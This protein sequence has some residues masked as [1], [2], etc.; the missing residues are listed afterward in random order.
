[1]TVRDD[2]PAAIRDAATTEL[3]ALVAKR[4]QAGDRVLVVPVL[5]SF[6]GIE[7]GIRKRLDGLDYTMAPQAIMPDERLVRLDQGAARLV[8]RSRDDTLAG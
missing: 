5:L 4:A 1:M 8:D 7:Q 2:A 3:R 6:G